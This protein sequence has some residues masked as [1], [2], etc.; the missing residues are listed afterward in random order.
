MKIAY[1][2]TYVVN[3]RHVDQW[4]LWMM[5]DH[6]LRIMET[7]CFESYRMHKLIGLSDS[8]DPTYSVQLLAQN[9]ADLDRYLSLYQEE[10]D[11]LLHRNFKD[12]LVEFRTTMVVVAEG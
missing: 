8:D 6:L 9:K 11:R 3:P 7:G 4:R 10:H 12:K 5:K 2:I 1:N